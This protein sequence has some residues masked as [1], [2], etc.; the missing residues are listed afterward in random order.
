MVVS[1]SCKEHLNRETYITQNINGTANQA[2]IELHYQDPR[3]YQI[4]IE[5]GLHRVKRWSGE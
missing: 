3:I 5:R 2:S 4:G 1:K